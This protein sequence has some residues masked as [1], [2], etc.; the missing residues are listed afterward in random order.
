MG[1]PMRAD[2]VQSS[3]PVRH[4]TYGCLIVPPGARQAAA[5]LP[6][7]EL[8]ERLGLRN[9]FGSGAGDPPD[10][11]S[12]LAGTESASG[13]I[14]DFGLKHASA[15]V[16]AASGSAALVS[17]FFAELRRMLDPA[18][19]VRFLNGV[20]RPMTYTGLAM[21]NFAY[22]HRVLQ[23]PASVMPNAFLI[24][25]SK[26]SA[27]WRKDWMER[28]TYFLPRYDDAGRRLSEGHAL[29]AA[30]GIPCIMR[31]FY[32]NAA[33][34]TPPGAYDFI[35]YFECADEDVPT[36]H[37]I[38]STLRNTARNPE[39][40]FVREGPMWHGRRAATWSALFQ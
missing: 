6:V 32:K 17:E 18:I 3:E 34:P 1:V 9:E 21:F 2:E 27:W 8:A 25:M 36:F 35:T 11:V 15:V 30:A 28:H 40:K 39:W 16:H 12:F 23:Q 29:A 14:E 24:P 5:G 20:V 38:C 19:G 10:A 31:R 33:E 4:G 7:A 22:A 37:E 13:D 26:T